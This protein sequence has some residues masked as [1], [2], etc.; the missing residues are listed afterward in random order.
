MMRSV[1]WVGFPNGENPGVWSRLEAASG[2]SRAGLR[3]G[4]R[5]RGERGAA[6]GSSAEGGR[7]LRFPAKSCGFAGVE[8]IEAE[9]RWSG[10]A[11]GTPG[12]RVVAAPAYIRYDFNAESTEGSVTN[13]IDVVT[14]WPGLMPLLDTGPAIDLAL[15]WCDR[16]LGALAALSPL[17]FSNAGA[18][19]SP[20]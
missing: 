3:I 9:R 20:G 16:A 8:F 19:P 11:P 1:I 15:T 6:A 10:L 4:R 13:P 5:R 17:P 12:S 14:N 18:L 2:K 7:I